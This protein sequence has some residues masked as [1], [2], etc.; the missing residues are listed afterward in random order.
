MALRDLSDRRHIVL[1]VWVE[2]R[3]GTG[4]EKW[5]GEVAAMRED[6]GRRHGFLA[7]LGMVDYP[8]Y[9]IRLVILRKAKG[10]LRRLRNWH[11]KDAGGWRIGAIEV[12]LMELWGHCSHQ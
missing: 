5:W 4:L 3:W 8:R 10:F 7:G 11:F 2:R 6:D 12:R 1:L 9:S